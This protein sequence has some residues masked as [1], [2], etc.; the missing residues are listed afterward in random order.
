MI[1]YERDLVAPPYK[2]QATVT[3]YHGQSTSSNPRYLAAQKGARLKSICFIRAAAT[4]GQPG[5]GAVKE[6]VYGPVEQSGHD[7][8]AD[9]VL[10]SEAGS[11]AII[12]TGDCPAVALFAPAHGKAVLLHAGRA[13]LTPRSNSDELSNIITS[14]FSRLTKE[15]PASRVIALITGSI[16]ANHFPHDLPEARALVEP[17]TVF[18]EHAFIDYATG[19]LNLVAIIRQQLIDLGVAE[20]DLHHDG[21]CTHEHAKLASNRRDPGVKLRNPVILVLR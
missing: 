9:G 18:G 13:A 11:A 20:S 2:S 7:I 10:L 6:P 8:A 14:G 21:L 16:C 4:F 12:R 19:R 17:F 15:L 3:L 5:F 1:V